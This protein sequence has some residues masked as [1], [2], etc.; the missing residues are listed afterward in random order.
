LYP[1]ATFRQGDAE[2]LGCLLAELPFHD[3]DAVR[4]AQRRN[5]EER[6]TAAAVA[7]ATGDFLLEARPG[8][9]AASGAAA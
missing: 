3:S 7:R 9:A 2:S 5:V 1:K 6:Y 4:T 8:K